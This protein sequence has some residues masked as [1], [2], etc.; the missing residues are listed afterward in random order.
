MY[1]LL[2][3][4]PSRLSSVIV[5]LKTPF[6]FLFFFLSFI[7]RVCIYP[8]LSLD[9][10]RRAAAVP[11]VFHSGFLSATRQPRF[12]RVPTRV[13]FRF[14]RPGSCGGTLL[15]SSHL[16]TV[17]SSDLASKACDP[18]TW[19]DYVP[20]SSDPSSA[21]GSHLEDVVGSPESLR[22]CSEPVV[23][24]GREQKPACPR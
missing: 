20:R 18:K 2:P 4:S 10:A 5:C 6:G 23:C 8:S 24:F 3:L 17:A 11:Y 12:L 13:L 14:G 15:S 21:S 22:V 7:R 16:W 9:A 19:A 1:Y